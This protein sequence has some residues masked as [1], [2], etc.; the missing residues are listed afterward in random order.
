M[1]R[2]YVDQYATESASKTTLVLVWLA[3]LFLHRPIFEFVASIF[4]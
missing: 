4:S 1:E 2:N 3:F